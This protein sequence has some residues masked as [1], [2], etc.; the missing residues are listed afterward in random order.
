M[1]STESKVGERGSRRQL[2]AAAAV[3]SKG[4][5]Q[6]REAANQLPVTHLNMVE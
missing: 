3:D 6:T 1:V 2:A 5:Q 4:K